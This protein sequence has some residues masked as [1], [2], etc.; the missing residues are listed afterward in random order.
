MF[1][2][3]FVLNSI[4]LYNLFLHSLTGTYCMCQCTFYCC[5]FWRRGGVLRLEFLI[6]AFSCFDWF[7]CSCNL[8]K[9]CVSFTLTSLMIII[10]PRKAE[11]LTEDNHSENMQN[12]FK[13]VKQRLRTSTL[14][15]L[16]RAPFEDFHGNAWFLHLKKFSLTFITPNNKVLFRRKY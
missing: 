1:L 13:K 5:C 9:L 10:I 11:N 2:L 14:F 4:M 6:Y 3:L 16:I 8:I 15:I 12:S 7:I